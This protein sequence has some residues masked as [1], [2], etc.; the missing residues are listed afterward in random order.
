MC[1]RGKL[2][3]WYNDT[4]SDFRCS[5]LHT[6]AGKSDALGVEVLVGVC[7]SLPLL[8]VRLCELVGS[9]VVPVVVSGMASA[10]FIDARPITGTSSAAATG[11]QVLT[12]RL[13]ELAKLLANSPP[14]ASDPAPS[15]LRGTYCRRDMQ[16]VSR[17]RRWYGC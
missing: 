7:S 11:A 14:G 4:K 1:P 13:F 12:W 6:A 5:N 10:S 8:G 17:Q 9:W 2:E 16:R 15:E 3:E